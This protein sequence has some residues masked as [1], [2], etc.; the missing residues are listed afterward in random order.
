MALITEVYFLPDTAYTAVEANAFRTNLA[1]SIYLPDTITFIGNDAF[2]DALNL[3]NI[4][5]SDN[6]TSIGN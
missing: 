3:V 6:I 1:T 5:L 4:N 2:R